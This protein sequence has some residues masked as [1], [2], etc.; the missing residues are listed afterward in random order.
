MPFNILYNLNISQP[1]MLWP[2]I[3]LLSKQNRL[4]ATTIC[5]ISRCW[6]RTTKGFKPCRWIPRFQWNIIWNAHNSFHL[7]GLDCRLD[8]YTTD[9]GIPYDGR[10]RAHAHRSIPRSFFFRTTDF[11]CSKRSW[12]GLVA[13]RITYLL[14]VPSYLPHV[15]CVSMRIS[16]P[17]IVYASMPFDSH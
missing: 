16:I 17:R 14:D 9:L 13:D 6:W 2:P 8:K 10:L 1:L 11:D 12:S 15:G 5:A 7:I 3:I 4:A